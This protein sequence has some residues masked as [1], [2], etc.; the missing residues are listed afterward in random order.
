MSLQQKIAEEKQKELIGTKLE[1]LV[2][3]KTFDNQYYVGRSYRE[4]PDIDGL[5]YIPMTEK[6]L[7]G[8]FIT[9]T[10]TSVQGYDLIAS[11]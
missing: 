4:V 2:E 8:K 11:L 5:I 3:T 1:V 9:C 7:L 10:I 6:D